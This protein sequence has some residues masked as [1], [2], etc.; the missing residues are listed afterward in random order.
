VISDAV[1]AT[2]TAA[3]PYRLIKSLFD[4]V[5]DLGDEA[6]QRAR[7]AELGADADTTARVLH[8]L[9]LA[10]SRT[11]FSQPVARALAEVAGS[12]LSPGDTLGPWRL[13]QPLG[14]GGM[15]Q[16]FLAERNDGHYQQRVAIKLLLGWTGTQALARLA[17]ERQILATLTHPHIARLLDGGTTPLGRPYLVME[18]IEGEAIDRHC[19]LRQLRAPARLALLRMVC[20]AVAAA[21]RQ[22]VVHCDIKPS[23]V[24]VGADGR[25]MLLDFGIAQL[26]DQGEDAGQRTL[27]LTPRYASPEQRAGAAPGPASDIYS[28]GQVIAEL[29][30]APEAQTPR[31]HEW[32]AIVVR[33][34][35]DDPA[36]RYPTVQALAEDLRR[37]EQHLPLQ[38][39]PHHP[40]YV[41]AK[42][43]RR[44]WPW[45][46]AATAA[47]AMAAAFT[48]QL[49]QQRDRALQA[50]QRAREQLRTTQAINDFVVG[51]FRGADPRITGNTEVSA[52]SVV[53]Q[54]RAQIGASL[55]GQPAQQA[56]L[57]GV[58]GEV[59]G[60]M[61]HEEPAI[62]VLRQAIAIEGPQQLNRPLRE[63]WLLERLAHRLGANGNP[64]QALPHARRALALVQAQPD[65]DLRALADAHA[66]LGEQLGKLIRTDEARP[67]LQRSLELAQQLYGPVHPR[68][69]GAHTELNDLERFAQRP[70]QAEWHGRQAMAIA[71][72]L[73]DRGGAEGIFWRNV[74]VGALMDQGKTA[75]A[76]PLQRSVVADAV[77]RF[78]PSASFT[79]EA[80]RRLAAVLRKDGQWAASVA[81]IRDALA[82]AERGGITHTLIHG[83]TEQMLGRTLAQVGDAAEAEVHLRRGLA[84]RQAHLGPD[85]LPISRSRTSLGSLMLWRGD[86]TRALAELKLAL[87]AVQ[88]MA[89]DKA[90]RAE[91]EL[92]LAQAEARTGQPDAARQ[93][94]AQLQPAQAAWALPQP[95]LMLQAQAWLARA[96]RQP[97]QAAALAAEAAA[98]L[99]PLG[100]DDALRQMLLMDRAD[101]LA[102]AG[103]PAEARAQLDALAPAVAP[104]PAASVLQQRL[105]ALR[106]TG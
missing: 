86:A 60:N 73:P 37:F 34:C 80:H 81:S 57:L 96:E 94:L 48:L 78:G 67:H 104:Y 72:Q 18:Y 22:L 90:D 99:K 68:V 69:A 87:P 105:R 62:E 23:N 74:L 46:L 41:T 56:E 4:A 19:Q 103:R 47:L 100:A 91:T 25:A 38:A 93:R 12:E 44:R 29:L 52:K 9:G 13:V 84:L 82:A 20:D 95:A 61:G 30:G 97:L 5:V 85:S 64:D 17:R 79:S 55:R 39:L 15:G 3:S 45:V 106:N 42:L 76:I 65:A 6:A 24:L 40:A 63:S 36:D 1:A 71:E 89:P 50:E 49:V 35:A 102:A 58:L 70:A 88:A 14:A 16:V 7:L 98:L 51:L 66:T 33:A 11:H 27:A 10:D 75:E 54:G 26:Q 2:V 77:R 8:M 83:N 21:H 59:Y 28:L 101:A 31:P 92:H 43:L 53:D 32:H